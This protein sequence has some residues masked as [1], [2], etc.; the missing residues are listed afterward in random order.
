MHPA[1]ISVHT[2]RG[3]KLGKEHRQRQQTIQ[4]IN[5]MSSNDIRNRSSDTRSSERQWGVEQE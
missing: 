5:R 3:S 2:Q 4:L 1:I